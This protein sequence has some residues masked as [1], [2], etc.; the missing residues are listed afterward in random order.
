[1][2]EPAVP[3]QRSD[4]GATPP[5]ARRWSV[6]LFTA[7]IGLALD[8]VTKHWAIATLGNPDQRANHHPIVL[9]ED[10]LRFVTVHNTGAVAGIASGKT[11]LLVSVSILAMG[12]IVYLFFTAPRGRGAARHLW[13]MATG[14]LL[15]GALGNTIDRLFND[16]KVID[17][18]EVNLHV[19]FADPWPTFNIA[20]SLL[21]VGVAILIG[22]SL[23][24]DRRTTKTDTTTP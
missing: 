6:F 22:L 15:A 16:G 17:F 9:I 1:M 20:D 21:C 2:T 10:I 11:A 8:M 7:A 23:F 24:N 5:P 13:P 18:I 19:R 4:P 14:M 3:Q 12:F